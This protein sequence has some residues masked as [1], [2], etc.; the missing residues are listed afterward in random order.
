MMPA[1]SAAAAGGSPFPGYL[2]LVNGPTGEIY[3][4]SSTTAN[5]WTSRTSSFGSNVINCIATD[6]ANWFVAVGNSGALATSPDGINWT[7]RTSSFGTT[8]IYWVAY[9]NGYWVAVGDSG[10]LATAT[11]P[12]GT[13]TQRTSGETV[14]IGKVVYGGEW[15]FGAAGGIVRSTGTDPTTGWTSRT[16]TMTGNVY[17]MGYAKSQDRYVAGMDGGTTGAFAS[18]PDG[19][20]WTARNSADSQTTGQYGTAVSTSSVIVLA[21]VAGIQTSTDA[22]TW[23]A[24]TEANAQPLNVAVDGS[25]LFAVVSGVNGSGVRIQTSTDGTTWTDQGAVGFEAGI[26]FPIVSICHSSGYPNL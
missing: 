11:N 5:S 16:S 21:T 25:G 15:V 3:T 19:T 1:A 10:K 12:T 22:A 14:T 13:W 8:A 20:T 7:Q 18:S 6:G 23:T 9:A 2:W 17:L 26:L 4:S 24:R